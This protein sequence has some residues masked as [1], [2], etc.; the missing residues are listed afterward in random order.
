[1][2]KI[3]AQ[4]ETHFVRIFSVSVL[5]LSAICI[6]NLE[7]V[8]KGFY[9]AANQRGFSLIEILMVVGIIAFLAVMV[10]GEIIPIGRDVNVRNAQAGVRMIASV[11]SRYFLDTSSAPKSIEDLLSNERGVQNWKGPYITPSQAL[12]PWKNRYVIYAPGQHSELDVVSFGE[13]GRE[14]GDGRA[15][16]IGSWQ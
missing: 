16:D 14:G 1:M 3:Y 15:A 11:T 7:V 2:F 5:I 12:D 8:M 4:Y 6:L 10:V 13:D 9:I